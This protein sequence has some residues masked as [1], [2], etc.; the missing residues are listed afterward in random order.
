MNREIV[1]RGWDIKNNCWVYGYYEDYMV[2]FGPH[3]ATIHV[4]MDWGLNGSFSVVPES[5]GQYI[6]VEDSTGKRIYEG[7]FIQTYFINKYN[8]TTERDGRPVEVRWDREGSGFI[9]FIDGCGGCNSYAM[10]GLS[11]DIYPRDDDDCSYK[12]LIIGNTWEN[13]KTSVEV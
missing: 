2:A 4:K 11:C 12:N 6:G 10:R 13:K 9:P 1:F 5:V 3:T 7:D 8:N